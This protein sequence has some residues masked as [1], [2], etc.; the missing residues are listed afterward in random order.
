MADERKRPD[1][2]FFECEK[3]KKNCS[4]LPLAQIEACRCSGCVGYLIFIPPPK[5]K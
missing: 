4:E 1:I 2:P 3:H 5:K